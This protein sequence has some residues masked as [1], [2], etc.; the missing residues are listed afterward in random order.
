MV[1]PGLAAEDKTMVH[2]EGVSPVEDLMREHG[3]SEKRRTLAPK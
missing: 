2:E 1:A 3:K